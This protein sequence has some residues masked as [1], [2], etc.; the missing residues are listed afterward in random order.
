MGRQISE[1]TLKIGHVRST[2]KVFRQISVWISKTR[3]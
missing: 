3:Q 1:H 2:E